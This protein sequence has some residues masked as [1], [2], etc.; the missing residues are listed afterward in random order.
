MAHM[1]NSHGLGGQKGSVPLVYLE[2]QSDRGSAY[3]QYISPKSPKNIRSSDDLY[4]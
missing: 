2:T 3:L 4:W 1:A